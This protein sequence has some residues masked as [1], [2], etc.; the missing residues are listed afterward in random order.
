MRL[1]LG[2]VEERSAAPPIDLPELLC[3]SA[4][5]QQE[6]EFGHGMEFVLPSAGERLRRS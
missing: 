6:V 3:T 5:V 4:L 2:T 1:R